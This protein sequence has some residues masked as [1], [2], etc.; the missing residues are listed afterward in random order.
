VPTGYPR[1]SWQEEDC[2]KHNDRNGQDARNSPA[3][4]HFWSR[5]ASGI[6]LCL[7]VKKTSLNGLSCEKIGKASIL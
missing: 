4:F 6:L 3:R 2:S 1:K 5:Y 7:T